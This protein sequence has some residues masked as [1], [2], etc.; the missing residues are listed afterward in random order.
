MMKRNSTLKRGKF[1]QRTYKEQIT[2]EQYHKARLELKILQ[3]ELPPRFAHITGLGTLP[4]KG[5]KKLKKQDTQKFK[6]LAQTEPSEAILEAEFKLAVRVRDN[7][8][9]Q[10][11]G[12]KYKDD[13]IEVHHINPRSRR[14]D[15][16][17]V[18][19]NGR[20]HCHKHHMKIHADPKQSIKDGWLRNRSRELARKEGTLGIY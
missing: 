13:H 15:L 14:K 10:W 6:E 5:N 17:Y 18:V 12:C 16:V 20:C 7:Y 8:T 11:P 19:N 4:S 2:F 3:L 9:C 1:K